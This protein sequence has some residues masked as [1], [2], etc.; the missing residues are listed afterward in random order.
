MLNGLAALHPA[1]G[2]EYSPEAPYPLAGDLAVG[3]VRLSDRPECVRGG[4]QRYDFAV[5]EL[6]TSCQVELDRVLLDVEVVTFASR[7]NPALVLQEVA[8]TPSEP[9]E[10]TLSALVSTAHVPGSVQ[11]RD[12]EVH[13]TDG[14]VADG[15]LNFQPPGALTSSGVACWSE[16]LGD[17]RAARS[18]APWRG[19]GDLET[20]F[21]L[22]ARRG[23]RY[24]LRQLVAMVPSAQHGVPDQHAVRLLHAGV[25]LGFDELRRR[26][27]ACWSEL[28]SGRVV[29]VGADEAWQ[30]RADA[31][32]Y[33][34]HASV[35]SSSPSSTSMFGL[36]QWRDYHYYYGH[37]MWDIEAFSIPP[38]LLT[39]PD[40]A[41]AMLGFRHR[42]TAAAR[43]NAQL[44]G[45]RGIQFPWEAG[46]SHGEEAAPLG[47]NGPIW[48]DHVTCVVAQAFAQLAYARGDRQVAQTMAWPVV[49]AAADW[50][51]SRVTPDR[52]RVRVLRAMGVAERSG[53]ADDD[54]FTTMAAVAVIRHA[55]RLAAWLGIEPSRDW[56]AVAAGLEVC[57]DDGVIL[58]HEGFSFD[59]PKGATP[60]APAGVLL[61]G[62]P[63]EEE[64][65]SRTR[66]AYLAR[67]DDYV[68]SP[69]L[70]SLLG[71]FAA[72]EGDR[73]RSTEL[74]EEGYAAY[75]SDRFANVHEYRPDRFPDEPVAGPFYANLSGFLLACTYGLGRLRLGPGAPATW[76]QDGPLVMPS[77]WDGVEIERVWAHG[78]PHRFLAVHGD[79]RARLEPAG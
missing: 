36:A 33:Y 65:A 69:M 9:C 2:I 67:A 76:C 66:R 32:T 38:L 29:L 56:A 6:H 27:A 48:E 62:H 54:A 34:L 17:G 78:R 31:A 16:L 1:L 75:C 60:S 30:R 37:V 23:R 77:A 22:A 58:D 73:N 45:R 68:G 74:F 8:V 39:Q 15:A 59:E 43:R 72:L 20:A 51:C 21:C 70:A 46:P 5:G 25:A 35:H 40:A 57:V 4:E 3:S 13:G 14:V 12:V 44:H 7:S 52:G 53:P 26:N 41:T 47:A 61:F 50:V 55:T 18:R 11:H 64:I 42:T 63:V 10:L 79:E 28:W 24:R 71:V 49:S 19:N